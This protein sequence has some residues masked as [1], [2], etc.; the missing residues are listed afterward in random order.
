MPRFRPEIETTSVL[1]T[2]AML[3][4]GTHVA[5]LP[6]MLVARD[7]AAGRLVELPVDADPW[8]RPLIIATRV[9]G[10]KPPLIDALVEQL[11]LA[12]REGTPLIA[13]T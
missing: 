6:D 7:L 10:P 12:A 8:T 5:I 9:R 2:L 1:F 13:D 4:R 3:D 11:T